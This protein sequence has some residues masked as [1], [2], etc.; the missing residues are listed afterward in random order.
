MYKPE[1]FSVKE[2]VSEKTYKQHSEASIN[3]LDERAL[4]TLDALRKRF[5]SCTINNWAWG[6]N[7]KH[8]GLR[9]IE[10]Y[11]SNEKFLKSR[12]QHKYG[13]A[14]DCKFK[15]HEAHEVRKYILEHQSEFPFITFLEVDIGW[16]H[17]DVR[18]GGEIACWSPDKGF[19]NS[20]QVIDCKL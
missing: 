8:S 3:M 6:G 12:S 14:F 20:Q 19:V 5:G 7:F 17:F 11:S 15:N 9:E 13:R 10:F 4:K 18:N 2:L 16:F 1:H